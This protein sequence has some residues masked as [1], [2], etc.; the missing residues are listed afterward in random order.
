MT[1]ISASFRLR[2]LWQAPLFAALAYKMFDLVS[3]GLL[4]VFVGSPVHLADLCNRLLVP[5]GPQDYRRSRRISE[6]LPWGHWVWHNSE[7]VRN[8]R[9]NSHSGHLLFIAVPSIDPQ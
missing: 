9:V 6:I 3:L 2:G 8:V 7:N 5:R 1:D 4:R